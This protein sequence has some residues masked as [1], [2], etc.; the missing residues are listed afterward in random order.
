[1]KTSFEG[2]SDNVTNIREGKYDALCTVKR[3]HNETNVEFMTDFLMKFREKYN[4]EFEISS[5]SDPSDQFNIDT[6]RGKQLYKG[7]PLEPEP[8]IVLQMLKAG[9]KISFALCDVFSIC[10]ASSIS[11]PHKLSEIEMIEIIKNVKTID[12]SSIEKVWYISDNALYAVW[13]IKHGRYHSYV[14]E[15]GTIFSSQSMIRT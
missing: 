2:I 4:L 11:L 10:D 6:V 5:S 14:K 12:V 9:M 8:S 7:I 15:D 3:E 1:M 13:S